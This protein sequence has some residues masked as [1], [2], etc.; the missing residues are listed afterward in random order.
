MCTEAVRLSHSAGQIVA[1]CFCPVRGLK[2]CFTDAVKGRTK[3]QESIHTTA[4]HLCH[5][6]RVRRVKMRVRQ[7]TV[8]TNTHAAPCCCSVHHPRLVT[9]VNVT[10]ATAYPNTSH[11]ASSNLEVYC[12]TLRMTGRNKY[13]MCLRTGAATLV[14]QQPGSARS[15]TVYLPVDALLGTMT[16]ST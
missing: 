16:P 2:L 5:P 8:H 11:R 9:E 6:A 14:T 12:S 10:Q 15:K 13:S 7:Y 3:T 4:T 1:H